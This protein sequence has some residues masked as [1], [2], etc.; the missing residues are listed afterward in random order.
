M[1]KEDIEKTC[2]TTIY[3]N[4]NY[5]VMPFGI[6]NIPATFQREMNRIFLPLIGK[7]MFVYMDDIVIF[8]TSL[9]QHMLDLQNVFNIIRNNGL[10]T[11]LSKCHFF[12]EE[13]E[14][15]GNVL[16]TEGVKPI[17]KKVESINKIQSPKDIRQL[18]SFLGAIGYYRK[19]IKGY[20][21]LAHPLFKLTKK[22]TK[23][24]WAN[25]QEERFQDLKGRLT[26]APILKYPNFE[27]PF[28]IRTDASLEGIGGVL[29]QKNE[30]ENEHSIH[31]VSRTLQPAELNYSINDLEGTAAFYCCKKFKSYPG[32]NKKKYYFVY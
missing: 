17:Q 29:I 21:Q 5:K 31:Y 30:N 26:K 10:K 11:N 2:F 15:I 3:S 20:A 12:K 25:E 28:I 6:C 14:L 32:G 9:E 19:F 16:S 1:Q 27:K 24:I 13:V 18:R 7:C 4:Y 23:F 22:N 8:S